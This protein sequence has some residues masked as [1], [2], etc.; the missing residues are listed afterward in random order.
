MTKTCVLLNGPTLS[1]KG[2]AVNHLMGLMGG[3]TISCKDHLHEL[4]MKMFN[5]APRH[6]W[7]LYSNREYKELPTP[8]YRV[9][10]NSKEH[11]KCVKM[12][13]PIDYS[14][15]DRCSVGDTVNLS[16]REVL[17]YVSECLMKPRFGG[18][19]FGQV[20][21]QKVVASKEEIIYDDS[22]AF[23]AELQPLIEEVGQE[24]IL[25]VRIHRAGY[26]FAGDS[27]NYI[28]D[29]VITNTVDVENEEGREDDYLDKIFNVVSEFHNKK[30]T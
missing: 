8:V 3:E 4:V 12:F 11:D 25:L 1:G 22:C 28:P 18:D 5:V 26:T 21:A 6:Y 23:V 7:Q 24:N 20:R 14:A 10:M 15:I 29:G 13:G 17:I 19:Y 9:T 16:P 30:R 2:I 27:R